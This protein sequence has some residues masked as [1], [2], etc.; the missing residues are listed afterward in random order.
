MSIKSVQNRV[1][2][3]SHHI[4]DL[5]RTKSIASA[6]E[7]HTFNFKPA[8]PVVELKWTEGGARGKIFILWGAGIWQIHLMIIWLLQIDI[9]HPLY[10]GDRK[11]PQHISWKSYL[12]LEMPCSEPK[13]WSR[14]FFKFSFWSDIGKYTLLTKDDASCDA[15][16]H[17]SFST[18]TSL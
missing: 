15:Q 6:Q 13:W 14:E 10:S 8:F 1:N 3:F 9:S 4:C 12:F 18:V 11:C 5:T 17:P 16:P 2:V 7:H